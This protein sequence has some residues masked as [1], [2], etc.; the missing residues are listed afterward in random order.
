MGFAG[1]VAGI[2]KGVLT[3]IFFGFCLFG[4]WWA[5]KKL[6]LDKKFRK[7]VK[8]DEEIYIFVIQ[9]VKS[10]K[11]LNDICEEIKFSSLPLNVQNQY[12][13][14]YVEVSKEILKGGNEDAKQK[15]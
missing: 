6:K 10:G 7:K 2:V 12:I 5:I 15:S 1:T 14:A 4:T 3:V 9:R 11:K 8:I 13:E